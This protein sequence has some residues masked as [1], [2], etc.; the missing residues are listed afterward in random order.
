MDDFFN[1]MISSTLQL[2]LNNATQCKSDYFHFFSKKKNNKQ[3]LPLKLSKEILP[4]SRNN[5]DRQKRF[6]KKSGFLKLTV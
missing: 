3:L 5:R 2:K 6:Y 1:N 4:G